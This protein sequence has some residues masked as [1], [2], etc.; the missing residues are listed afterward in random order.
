MRDT[1]IVG[2]E[3]ATGTRVSYNLGTQK[4]KYIP[5]TPNKRQIK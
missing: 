4:Y 1:F 2:D 5:K 3:L